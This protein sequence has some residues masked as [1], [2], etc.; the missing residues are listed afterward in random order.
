VSVSIAVTPLSIWVHGAPAVPLR[1]SP[2]T[3]SVKSQ[4]FGPIYSIVPGAVPSWSCTIPVNA[5]VVLVEPHVNVCVPVVYCQVPMNAEVELLDELL[6]LQASAAVKRR[7]HP[8]GDKRWGKGMGLP[9][10]FERADGAHISLLMRPPRAHAKKDAASARGRVPAGV[11]APSRIR[12]RDYGQRGSELWMLMIVA[13]VAS[14]PSEA[15]PW[16]VLPPS[17]SPQRKSHWGAACP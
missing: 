3:L 16:D 17:A 13:G 11:D 7:A 10:G 2:L 14:G 15:H 1:V 9:E 5:V 8:S 4:P 6:L 12:R